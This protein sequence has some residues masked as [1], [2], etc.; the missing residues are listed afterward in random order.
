MTTSTWTYG[1]FNAKRMSAYE[2]ASTF[3]APPAFRTLTSNDHYYVIGPRGSGKTTLLRMLQGESLMAWSGDFADEI[4]ERVDYSAIFLPADELWASQAT[5]AASRAAFTTQML[6]AF[7]ETMLYRVAS[8]DVHGNPVHLPARLEHDEEVQLVR[9]CAEAWGLQRTRPSLYGLQAALDLTLLRLSDDPSIVAG[10]LG[11][12]PA[13]S[14]LAFGIRAFN[15]AVSQPGHQWALLLDE[16]ELAPAAIHEEVV[17]FARG[18]TANLILKL[19]M[20]PFDRYMD[21]VGVEGGPIPGHDFQTIHLSGQSR[22]EIR[23]LTEGLWRESLRSRGLPMV[24]MSHALGPTG[25]GREGGARRGSDREVV[26]LLERARDQDAIFSRWLNSKN[27]DPRELS[28]LSYFERSSTVRK[29]VP[30][31]VFREALLNFRQGA[32]VKRSRKKSVEPFTGVAAVTAALEGNPRWIKLAFAEML[33]YFDSSTG[34]VSPG[35]QFD[36]LSS[37]ANR[38]E[39]LLRVLPRKQAS[40]GAMPVPELVE[41]ISAYFHRKNTG[42]F[43]ADPQNCFTID[44]RT[45]SWVLDGIV[46]GLYAGAFVHVRDRRSPSVLSSLAGQRFRLAYLLGVRDGREF[47]LRLG[48]DASLLEI[49]GADGQ[50]TSVPRVASVQPELEF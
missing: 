48:K 2:V 16:M 42:P 21:A 22:P 15:R 6:Y 45:P 5:G 47:P 20:S 19:S 46:M 44:R 7:V 23:R 10:P 50:R 11:R 36:A 43:S 29:V 32:P 31:L 13:M 14:L 30:I 26:E 12:A 27:V 49:I 41:T 24:S 37:L 17:S 40:V 35:F 8:V 39:A 33:N 34:T 3:V 18:G 28:R 25:P 4:R 38:F 9:E 1:S